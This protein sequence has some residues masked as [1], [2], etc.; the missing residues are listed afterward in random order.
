MWTEIRECFYNKNQTAY[1]RV[2]FIPIYSTYMWL[3]DCRQTIQISADRTGSL[4]II[5]K[6]EEHEG[7]ESENWG[8]P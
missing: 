1:Y 6:W 2:D 8:A 5:T 7:I 3:C 4:Q